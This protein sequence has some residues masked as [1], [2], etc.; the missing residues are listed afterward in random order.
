MFEKLFLLVKD[1]AGT[2]VINNPVI[3]AKYHEAV[4]NEASSSIIEVLKGQLESGKVKELIKYFQFSGSYNNSLVSS[5]TNSFASKL[6]IFYSIDPASALAAAKALIPT[7]MNELVKETKSGEAKEFA[8]GTML[9][10]LNGNRADL[11][12]LVNNLMVA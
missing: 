2:A 3:P 4:I 11:A 9:T 12:P 8:L 1:N 7:V 6:N 10:K 5:I